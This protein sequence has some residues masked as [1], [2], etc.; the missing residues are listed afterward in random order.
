MNSQ[1]SVKKCEKGIE[2][3][4]CKVEISIKLFLRGIGLS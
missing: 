3:K 2:H 1:K 4:Y